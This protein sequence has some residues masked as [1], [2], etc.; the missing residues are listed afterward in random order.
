MAALADQLHLHVA[1]VILTARRCSRTCPPH[2]AGADRG[3]RDAFR[4]APQVPRADREAAPRHPTGRSRRHADPSSTRI[5]ARRSSRRGRMAESTGAPEIHAEH[6]RL[7]HLGDDAV[8]RQPPARHKP[9]LFP[10][11]GTDHSRPRRDLRH[12]D[13]RAARDRLVLAARV[14]TSGRD[15]ALVSRAVRVRTSRSGAS[16]G[17]RVRLEQPDRVAL[18]VKNVRRPPHAGNR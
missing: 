3:S 5:S 6:E 8:H 15:L 4:A 2:P 10:P 7:M 18:R 12:P 14:R 11:P 9:D 16:G 1:P 13:A 17:A